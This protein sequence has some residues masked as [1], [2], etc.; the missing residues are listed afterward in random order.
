MRLVE[1]ER[2]LT[3]V[4]RSIELPLI[5]ERAREE[6]RGLEL[7]RATASPSASRSVRRGSGGGVS[8]A[9]PTNSFDRRRAEPV[10]RL[11]PAAGAMPNGHRRPVPIGVGLVLPG[12]RDRSPRAR[13][14]VLEPL[15]AALLSAVVTIATSSA[16]ASGTSCSRGF[17]SV[18]TMRCVI[19]GSE[20]PGKGWLRNSS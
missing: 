17:G 15:R 16:L 10:P 9:T 3:G 7:R 13:L 1:R 19:C 5:E 12:G 6:E 8:C 18:E 4:Q 20:S 2:L 14:G 11:P